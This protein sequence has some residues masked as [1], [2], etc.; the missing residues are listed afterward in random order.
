MQ[1]TL[2]L[3]LFIFMFSQ[4]CFASEWVEIIDKVYVN[5]DKQDNEY[6]FYWMKRLNNKDIPR[7]NNK[8]VYYHL[9]Y[10]VDNCAN[11]TTSESL[12]AYA[13]SLTGE[14]LDS[15]ISP[16][17]N[18]PKYASFSPIVPQSNGEIFHKFICSYNDRET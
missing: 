12:A 13:Y 14:V 9:Y 3:M 5:I 2:F 11:N 15:H 10:V 18:T 7:I 4:V 6:I 1:K 16:Y 17:F 8:Q